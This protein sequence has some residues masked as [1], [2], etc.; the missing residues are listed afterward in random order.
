MRKR[1]VQRPKLQ[2][3]GA[4]SGSAMKHHCRPARGRTDNLEIAP[5]KPILTGDAQ[6]LHRRLL[7]REPDCEGL[8][9]VGLGST[10]LYFLLGINP[11][12]EPLAR[13]FQGASEVRKVYQV[14]SD[15]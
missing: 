3:V 4:S 5:G 7:G 10:V 14:E 15:A 9:R 1:N 13:S 8:N 11:L 2:R 12:N 6:S